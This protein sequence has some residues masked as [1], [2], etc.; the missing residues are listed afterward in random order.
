MKITLSKKSLILIVSI[1][2]IF[3][4]FGVFAGVSGDE[5]EPS[6]ELNK[7]INRDLEEVNGIIKLRVNIYKH[8]DVNEVVEQL[9]AMGAEIIKVNAVS[10]MYLV[11]LVDSS[12]LYD[13]ASIKEVE[14]IQQEF[15]PQTLMNRI[16]SNTYM[17]H[18]TPQAGGYVGNGILAEVQ[19]NGCDAD[20]V[21]EVG[22]G[23]GHPDLSNVVWTDGAVV[24]DAHGTCTTGIMFGTGAGNSNTEGI[25]PQGTGAFAQ[26]GTGNYLTI[27]NLW[28]GTFTEGSAGMNGIAQSNSW[29][30]GYPMT[31]EYDA[32][33]NEIDWHCCPL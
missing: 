27:S 31:S 2:F 17:G 32:Y 26:W 15:E 11:C 22:P 14:W 6:P 16:S 25:L 1:L 13:I 10:V 33:S 20:P 28:S 30:S 21:P 29:W 5:P 4:Y 9:G 24:S 12:F 19:D 7:K 23:N 8:A 18:D 3:S